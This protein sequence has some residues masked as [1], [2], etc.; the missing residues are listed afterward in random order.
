MTKES[1]QLAR[2]DKHWKDSTVNPKRVRVQGC[3]HFRQT[4]LGLKVRRREDY[5]RAVGLGG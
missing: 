1:W 5:N 4:V 2:G 3:M